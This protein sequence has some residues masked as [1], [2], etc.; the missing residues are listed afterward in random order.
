[1]ASQTT[2][3][4][5]RRLPDYTKAIELSPR[6]STAYNNRGVCY[7]RGGRRDD[8]IADYEAAL[9]WSPGNETA[10]RNL[11]GITRT[12]IARPQAPVIEVPRFELP[13]VQE[14]LRVPEYPIDALPPIEAVDVEQKK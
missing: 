14:L 5:A 9:K 3:R 10:R 8:A 6:Y 1:L 13:P 2:G 11:E 12:T 4:R 7:S